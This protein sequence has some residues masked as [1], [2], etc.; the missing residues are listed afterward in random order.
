MII[1]VDSNVLISAILNPSGTPSKAFTKAVTLPN[2]AVICQQNIEEVIKTFRTKF[3][4]KVDDIRMFFI[5]ASDALDIIPTPTEK[6][7]SEN[8]IRDITDRPILRAA[9][10]AKADI[11]L[12]GDKDFLEAGLSKPLPMTPTQFL[13]YNAYESIKTNN[14]FVHDVQEPYMVNHKYSTSSFYDILKEHFNEEEAKLLSIKISELIAHH[15]KK[16]V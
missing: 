7:L 3:P 14:Y 2:K 13:L 11:I 5:T 15:D 9:I 8:K 16:K 1:F 4:Y 12:T 10:E 6:V